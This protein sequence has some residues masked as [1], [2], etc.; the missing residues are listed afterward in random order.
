[1]RLFAAN[2]HTQLHFLAINFL[3]L[4]YVHVVDSFR[5]EVLP[6][7]I[8]SVEEVCLSKR[9]HGAKTALIYECEKPSSW[10][11]EVKIGSEE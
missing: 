2:G 4:F 11:D 9:V 10:K 5:L 1:M 8:H 3:G 7:F 6:F